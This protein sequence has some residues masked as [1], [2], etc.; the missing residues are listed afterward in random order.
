SSP[1]KVNARRRISR[2]SSNT[3]MGC[4]FR[5]HGRCD[6]TSRL[7]S[8]LR[9]EL[10][11][12]PFE[13]NGNFSNLLYQQPSD[14]PPITFQTVGPGTGREVFYGYPYNFEPRLGLAW[15]PFHDGKT[16]FRAG[17]G[18]FHDRVFGNLFTNLKG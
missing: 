15:D 12:P 11:Q 17:Y 10:D 4:L 6:Q 14:V 5:T 7:P 9:Y 8:V 18:I 1:R 13:R 2:D 3:S 16:S